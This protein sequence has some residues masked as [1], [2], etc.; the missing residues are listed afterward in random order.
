MGW[1]PIVI[2]GAC[3]IT[4]I[5]TNEFSAQPRVVTFTHEVGLMTRS[6]PFKRDCYMFL[7]LMDT[8]YQKDNLIHRFKDRCQQ[9]GVSVN[10]TVI[11]LIA[12]FFDGL[13]L[14]QTSCGL[15]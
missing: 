8:S 7:S 5:K 9:I 11:K 3:S 6:K 4:V 12:S 14:R 2:V 15:L 1:H 10:N 13:P